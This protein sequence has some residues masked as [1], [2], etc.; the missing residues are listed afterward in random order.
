MRENA[1]SRPSFPSVHIAEDLVQGTLL[2]ALKARANHAGQASEQTWLIGILKHTFIDCFRKAARENTQEY[3]EGLAIDED[4]DFFD[5][6][7]NWQ[8]G[9]ATW[10]KPDKSLE[11]EQFINVLQDC[12]DRLPPKAGAVVYLREVDGMQCEEICKTLLISG[13][14]IFG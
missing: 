10:S 12:I 7:G 1:I 8:I 3:E 4:D 9:L 2:V 14:I 5:C 11:Q 13:L 6:Q